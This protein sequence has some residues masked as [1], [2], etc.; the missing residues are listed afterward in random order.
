[1]ASL[2]AGFSSRKED[3]GFNM[4]DGS[5]KAVEEAQRMVIRDLAAKLNP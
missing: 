2:E 3:V 1:L 4:P 5:Q